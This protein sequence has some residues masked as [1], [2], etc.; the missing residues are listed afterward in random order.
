VLCA[1]TGGQSPRRRAGGRDADHGKETA[2][3]LARLLQEGKV[4]AI[5]VSNFDSDQTER[6]RQVV[7]VR[8]MQ[9]PYN[10]FKRDAE[11]DLLPYAKETGLVM[12][13]YGAL[14]RGLLSGRMSEATAFDGDDLRRVDPKFQQPRF[15]QY[16]AAVAALDGYARENFR[17][18]VLLL[19]VRW[20]LD[21]GPTIA[22]L[23]RSPAG[24]ARCGGAGRGL[25]A[26]RP[27]CGKPIVFSRRRLPIRSV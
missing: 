15:S 8:T 18:N 10:L 22:L 26:R 17:K 6:F 25:V 4:R 12:L 5:G 2:S 14:C 16:L 27:R 23:G 13:A 7:R 1:G 24:P 9:P 11:R 21:K 19:A 20:I 3:T